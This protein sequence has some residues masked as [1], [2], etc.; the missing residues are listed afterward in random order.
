VSSLSVATR[1]CKKLPGLQ[2]SKETDKKR[3]LKEKS[4][5]IRRYNSYANRALQEALAT[6]IFAMILTE[7]IIAEIAAVIDITNKTIVVRLHANIKSVRVTTTN[8]R[9]TSLR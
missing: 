4:S 1:Q 7:T 9:G 8:A 3:K 5:T 6:V 2:V